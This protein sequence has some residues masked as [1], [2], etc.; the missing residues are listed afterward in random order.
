LFLGIFFALNSTLC[1][2]NIATHP[3]QN[4]CLECICLFPF[5]H[6]QPIYAIMFEVIFF[7][8]SWDKFY[9]V[10]CEKKKKD[11]L[12]WN[13]NHYGGKIIL[14]MLLAYRWPYRK[15]IC[16]QFPLTWKNTLF[17]F[18]VSKRL[19]F[20]SFFLFTALIKKFTSYMFLVKGW[21]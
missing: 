18:S 9:S 15:S 7:F 11:Q 5:F 12:L 6:F 8:N 13:P 3:F 19:L 4:W 14:N 16:I 20:S 17:K 21:P 10:C 2:I 1:D